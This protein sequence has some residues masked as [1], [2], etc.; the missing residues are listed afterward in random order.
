LWFKKEYRN[1]KELPKNM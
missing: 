1:V